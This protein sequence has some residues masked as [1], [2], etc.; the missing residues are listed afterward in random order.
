MTNKCR[1]AEGSRPNEAAGEAV[2]PPS[3]GKRSLTPTDLDSGD[4]PERRALISVDREAVY[5]IEEHMRHAFPRRVAA[6]LRMLDS[7][8]PSSYEHLWQLWDEMSEAEREILN[9][10]TYG[11]ARDY[12]AGRLLK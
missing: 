6:Y 11:A 8:I 1:P 4:S 10:A 12:H 3:G 5:E 2:D 7:P 9:K